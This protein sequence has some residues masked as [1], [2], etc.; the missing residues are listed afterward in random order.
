[1]T[2]PAQRSGPPRC[3]V[4]GVGVHAVNIPSALQA[5]ADAVRD[6]RKGYVCV[7]G[8]HGVMEAQ[9][10]AEMRAILNSAFLNVPD[11]MPMVW[12]GRSQGFGDMR[13][14]YGPEFMLAVCEAS[15]KQGWR[16]FL[17]G[18]KPGVAESLKASLEN[19]FPGIQVAGT[20][21]PPFRP[22]NPEEEAALAA[23]VRQA[24]PDCFWVGLSTPK[25]EAFMSK[26]LSKLDAK[27]MFGVG[28]AFDVWTGGI[29]DAPAWMKKSGLQWAHRLVQEP[30]RLWRRYAVIVPSFLGLILLQALGLKKYALDR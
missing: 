10:N 14:V 28:A 22:L 20:Y 7:T 19:R 25:Q 3:N 2:E 18:G 16:H 15:V 24:R 21:T 9:K 6:S 17:Y 12:V 27:V 11:G 30:R 8:V 29:K 23:Q 26:F 1:M 4:L 13:R 5:V